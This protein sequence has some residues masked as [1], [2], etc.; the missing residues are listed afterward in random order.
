MYIYIYVSISCIFNTIFSYAEGFDRQFEVYKCDID[1]PGFREFHARVQPLLL[2]Y[3]DAA[4]YI[5]VDDDRWVYY[6]V[7]VSLKY[8]LNNI[9]DLETNQ[10]L[11][12]GFQVFG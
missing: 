7:Y 6:V 3:V 5:D 8:F 12:F 11:N 1:V 4:S 10:N 2:F 9:I